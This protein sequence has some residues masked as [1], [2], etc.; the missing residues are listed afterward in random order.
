MS[1]L[2]TTMAKLSGIQKA[3]TAAINENVSRRRSAGEV[4]TRTNY[5]PGRVGHYFKQAA[6]HVETL[7]RLLPNLYGDFQQ[8][9]TE[10]EAAMMPQPGHD[11]MHYSRSQALRLIRDID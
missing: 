2:S 1:E 9:Q 8:I 5:A 6:A 10:A 11:P 4:L 7:R 3:L